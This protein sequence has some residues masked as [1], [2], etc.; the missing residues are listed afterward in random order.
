[1]YKT[2]TLHNNDIDD[3]EGFS[4]D[5]TIWLT[6][7]KKKKAQKHREQEIKSQRVAHSMV[8]TVNNWK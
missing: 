4:F 1:M 7:A 5:V 8:Q 3:N 6:M 2:L